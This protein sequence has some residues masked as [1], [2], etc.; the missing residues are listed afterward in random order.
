[1]RRGLG[2]LYLRGGVYWYHFSV[3]GKLVRA[4]THKKD[5]AEALQVYLKARADYGVGL[6]DRD[7]LTLEHLRAIVLQD[8][9]LSGHR[10]I[11]RVRSAFANLA[12]SFGSEPVS[13]IT[14]SHL[15]RYAAARKEAGA[16][17]ATYRYELVILKRGMRL[18]H[19]EGRL[20]SIPPFPSI[21]VENARTGFFEPEDFIRIHAL[22]PADVKNLVEFLYLTGWRKDEAMHLEW[23]H[24]DMKHGSIHLDRGLTKNRAGRL[25]PFAADDRL[26]SI[27]EEQRAY[28]D[29]VE[30]ERR[31]KVPWVFHRNGLRVKSFRTAWEKARK[32]AGLESALVHDFRRTAARRFIRAGANEKVTMELLGHKT[33]SMLDR[34]NVLNLRDMED[35]VRLAARYEVSQTSSRPRK[36]RGR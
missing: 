24:V 25:L 26:K 4:S 14:L 35:A 31:V 22:L 11:R 30:L 27:L 32:E 12:A 13:T 18:A 17:P 5:E 7:P 33:R 29:T 10:S 21:R 6:D 28:T 19:R 34:Y 1:M 15:T 16:S 2:G 20:A 9:T 3:R 23:R 8:Y 36:R